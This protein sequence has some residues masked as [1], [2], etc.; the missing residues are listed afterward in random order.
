LN[1]ID[2]DEYFGIFQPIRLET[3]F[4]LFFLGRSIQISEYA[5]KKY[6]DL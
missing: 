4:F 5:D 2:H 3:P 1:L 6:Y